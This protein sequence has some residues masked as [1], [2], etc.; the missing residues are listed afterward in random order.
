MYEIKII[1]NKNQIETGN[2][3]NISIYNWGGAYQP[4]ATAI[5]CFIEQVGFI[6]KLSCDEKNPRAVFTKQNEGVC[7]DSCLEFFANFK[8]KKTGSGYMNFEGNAKG[9]LLC[10]YGTNRYHRKTIMQMGFCHPEPLPYQNEIS[11]GFELMIPLSLINDVYGDSTFSTG[12]IIKG[13]FYKCGDDCEVPHYGSY[14]KI[15]SDHPDFHLPEY[16]SDMILVK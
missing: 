8:P 13:N 12:D 11:W 10:C 4:K 9:S 5:L 6:V 3:A 7:R 14:T 16:F 15:N 1:E 2:I